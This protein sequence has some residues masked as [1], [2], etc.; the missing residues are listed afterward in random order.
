M[1]CSYVEALCSCLFASSWTG[2]HLRN[3]SWIW[4]KWGEEEK[5][6]ATGRKRK[7]ATRNGKEM[8]WGVAGAERDTV[9]KEETKKGRDRLLSTDAGTAVIAGR[10]RG[11]AQWSF[12]CW[13]MNNRRLGA[14]AVRAATHDSAVVMQRRWLH[15]PRD[16]KNPGDWPPTDWLKYTRCARSWKSSLSLTPRVF[17]QQRAANFARQI[18]RIDRMRQFF[19][20]LFTCQQLNS[21][22]SAML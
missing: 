7:G 13:A 21:Q 9:W 16:D 12:A 14:A 17:R 3:I 10:E 22:L 2:C 1:A 5:G 6:K 11:Q 19:V 15:Q 20:V 18:T 4:K 8:E